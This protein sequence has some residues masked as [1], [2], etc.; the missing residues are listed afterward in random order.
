MTILRLCAYIKYVDFL[1]QS[2]EARFCWRYHLDARG[3]SNHGLYPDD[4]VPESYTR[5][6]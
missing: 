1:D 2:H 6:T 5:K 3:K 4:R